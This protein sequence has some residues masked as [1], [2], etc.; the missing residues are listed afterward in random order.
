MENALEKIM[1]KGYNEE[2]VKRVEKHEQ[3]NSL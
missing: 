2:V 3:Q 1:W